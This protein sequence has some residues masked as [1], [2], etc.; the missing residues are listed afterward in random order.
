MTLI[1]YPIWGLCPLKKS[2]PGKL[3]LRNGKQEEGSGWTLLWVILFALLIH[4]ELILLKAHPS[5]LIVLSSSCLDVESLFWWV[6][7]FFINGCLAISCN[8]DEL[9]RGSELKVLLLC[10]LVPS[11]SVGIG[12]GLDWSFGGA[13]SHQ[14]VNIHQVPSIVRHFV[15]CTGEMGE[16]PLSS[17]NLRD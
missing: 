4:L 9:F 13:S 11:S 5:C 16:I 17:R 1:L 7:V 10:H 15:Q 14:T 6:P 2:V 12:I 8:F 3:V